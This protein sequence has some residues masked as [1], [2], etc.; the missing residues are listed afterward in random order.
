MY[1]ITAQY[2]GRNDSKYNYKLEKTVGRDADSWFTN[3]RT[4]ILKW[5]RKSSKSVDRIITALSKFRKIE[6][7]YCED[8]R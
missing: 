8:G 1:V 2:K 4:T 5:E 7:T 3:G 6:V